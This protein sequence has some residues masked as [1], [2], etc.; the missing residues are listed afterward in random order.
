VE[1]NVVKRQTSVTALWDEVKRLEQLNIQSYKVDPETERKLQ[2]A[3]SAIREKYPD[4]FTNDDMESD[5]GL[6]VADT[7]HRIIA[8]TLNPNL[9]EKGL[10]TETMNSIRSLA[11]DVPV[12][13]EVGKFTLTSCS[14]RE[15]PCDPLWGGLRV[16]KEPAASG[17]NGSTLSFRATHST[18]G[19][20]FVVAGHEADAVGNNIAQP[21]GTG[22]IVGQ[23][24]DM[25]N[26]GGFSCDCAFVKNTSTRGLENKIYAP[27]VGSTYPI[28]SR[29]G[30]SSH[31]KGVFL[32]LSSVNGV[33]YGDIYAVTST[34]VIINIATGGGDSG[35]PV[36]KPLTS[37]SANLY[38]M[39]RASTG[40]TQSVYVPW[41]Y[42]KSSLSLT[43]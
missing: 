2:A 17:E 16:R 12:K 19:A 41:H 18:H 27:E 42:I 35:G 1:N 20:G 6:I 22:N 37:G 3:E 25:G 43:D 13:F 8:V 15:S 24:K 21:T 11:G 23:T 28:A 5:V 9:I 29:V 38:G 39:L 33:K 31:V 10:L 26:D 40:G 32:N 14:G 7:K 36:Y 34:N 4:T 30:S